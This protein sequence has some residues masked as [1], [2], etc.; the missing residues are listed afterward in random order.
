MRFAE[1]LSW[2]FD[3]S[4]AYDSFLWAGRATT[5]GTLQ[6]DHIPLLQVPNGSQ[7]CGETGAGPVDLLLDPALGTLHE[8]VGTA[9]FV[10]DRRRAAPPSYSFRIENDLA[11]AREI[12]NHPRDRSFRSSAEPESRPRNRRGR[13]WS[14]TSRRCPSATPAAP[15]PD[16]HPAGWWPAFPGAAA[17]HPPGS[18]SRSEPSNAD[19]RSYER[20][21][22]SDLVAFADLAEFAVANDAC[23]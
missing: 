23:P 1:A 14:S 6:R 5:C 19:P 18:P 20:L 10:E 12:G 22:G 16:K 4:M 2:V 15:G 9:V 3:P 8:H 11:A 21:A 7:P 17:R 13:C